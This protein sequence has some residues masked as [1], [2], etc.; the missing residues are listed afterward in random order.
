MGQLWDRAAEEVRRNQPTKA[1]PELVDA[2]RGMKRAPKPA[3]AVSGV[4]ISTPS[5]STPRPV[6]LRSD[7]SVWNNSKGEWWTPGEAWWKN[8]DRY[9]NDPILTVG[10][11][12]PP[13]TKGGVIRRGC[14]VC[15][16]PLVIHRVETL[17]N[18]RR[19]HWKG[20]LCVSCSVLR[21]REELW[22]RAGVLVTRRL[23]QEGYLPRG[24]G[25]QHFVKQWSQF[26]WAARVTSS[27]HPE[28]QEVGSSPFWYL[29]RGELAGVRLPEEAT[30]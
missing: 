13:T 4:E 7:G 3:P 2:L 9:S 20:G 10:D 21:E 27:T 14:I 30:A 23:E 29:K 26:T 24:T 11:P 25:D 15:G 1:P 6:Y 8:H 17:G 19:R 16:D 18:P 22:T 5:T 12:G 28:L